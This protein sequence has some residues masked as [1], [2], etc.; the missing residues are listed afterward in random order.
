MIR[1]YN[2]RG[3]ETA[4]A[5]V[6]TVSSKIRLGMQRNAKV[7]PPVEDSDV[8]TVGQQ[9]KP[10]RRYNSHGIEIANTWVAEVN[11]ELQSGAIDCSWQ[12]L[13]HPATHMSM[14]SPLAPAIPLL[15]D[16]LETL[17]PSSLRCW[18]S[19]TDHEIDDDDDKEEEDNKWGGVTCKHVHT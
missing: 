16:G 13:S 9:S 7:M 5:W 19:Y 14:L 18:H 12:A 15:F 10:T 4:N 8:P 1:R 6:A 3:I 11:S 2:P 17:D